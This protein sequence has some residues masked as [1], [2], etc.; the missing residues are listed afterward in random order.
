M[1]IIFTENANDKALRR[2]LFARKLTERLQ[3]NTENEA[4][5][6]SKIFIHNSVRA[7]YIDV[8]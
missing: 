3:T 8:K 5:I 1:Q 7:C 6:H 4:Y 2:R